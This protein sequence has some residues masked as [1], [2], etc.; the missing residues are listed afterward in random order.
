MMDAACVME[1]ANRFGTPLYLFDEGELRSQAAHL[2]SLLGPSVKLCYAMKANSFVLERAAQEVERIEV[3]S[4]GEARTCFALGI[5][6]ER[7]VISGVHKESSFIDEFVLEHPKMG[8]YTVESPAQFDL[9]AQ[10]ARKAGHPIR[11]LMRLTSGN[12][13]GMTANEVCELA[14]RCA[15]TPLVE[16]DGIQ[17]YSGTQKT[18]LKRL[19]RELKS[20]DA[21]IERLRDEYGIQTRELEFGPGLPVSYYESEQDARAQQDELAAGLGEL[22]SQMAFDGSVVLELGRAL[23]ASCGTYATRVCDTKSNKTGNYAIVDGGKHQFVY[24]GNAMS[25]QQPPCVVLPQRSGVAPEPW[26]FCGSLCTVTDILVK[27]L[28]VV[29]LQLG[30]MLAFD[31]AGAYCMTEGISMF[32]SRDLPRV[33]M[34]DP[35]GGLR[36]VRDRIETYPYNTPTI[37]S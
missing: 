19:K 13:F 25:M 16:F 26:N 12:Q 27:Q 32:L 29:D 36:L 17:H 34:R 20:I 35:Q 3:C 37:V 33:V 28:E 6:D 31:R 8:H 21:L 11:L 24:Y 18:S 2:R 14:V 30:D 9:L 4:E 10:A 1:A 22:L 15:S 7:L 5:P 23:V